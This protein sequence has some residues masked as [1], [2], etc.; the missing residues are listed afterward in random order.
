M[1]DDNSSKNGNK[2]LYAEVEE[3]AGDKKTYSITIAENLTK[4]TIR[5]PIAATRNITLSKPFI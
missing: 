3:P 4:P 2:F 1:Y 5:L